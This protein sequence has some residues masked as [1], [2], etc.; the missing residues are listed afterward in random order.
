MESRREPASNAGSDERAP[1]E[2][3]LRVDRAEEAWQ[4]QV[5]G[6]DAP[7]PT[8]IASFL[9]LILLAL[10]ILAIVF[11]LFQRLAQLG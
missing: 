2:G 1:E 8:P 10:A 7:A 6:E 11:L 4:R 5:A 9:R 3:R